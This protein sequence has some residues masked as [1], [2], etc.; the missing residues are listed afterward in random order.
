MA[1]DRCYSEMA[2]LICSRY[3]IEFSLKMLDV[4]NDV[5][6]MMIG[7]PDRDLLFTRLESRL[8]VAF[9]QYLYAH[10]L[11]LLELAADVDRGFTTIGKS[12]L[13]CDLVTGT[14]CLLTLVKRKPSSKWYHVVASSYSS[15][16]GSMRTVPP[17][18]WAE[19][20]VNR[21][22]GRQFVTLYWSAA[23]Y[24][25]L[26]HCYLAFPNVTGAMIS[27][28]CERLLVPVELM[29]PFPGITLTNVIT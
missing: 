10:N 4:L 15:K 14:V 21:P 27:P 8:N 6:R 11:K 7:C 22:L 17:H 23:G 9:V 12:F 19:E 25:Q 1:V 28:D 29:M 13:N 24:E 3:A 26:K 20:G 2:E 5:R 16:T 18:G